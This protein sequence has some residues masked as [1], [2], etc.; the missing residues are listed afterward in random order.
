MFFFNL[1]DHKVCLFTNKEEFLTLLHL[2]AFRQFQNLSEE[3]W[4]H[5]TENLIKLSLR[6]CLHI[7]SVI[8]INYHY[9]TVLCPFNLLNRFKFYNTV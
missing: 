7:R 5:A 9:V 6:K 1:V 8:S 2:R 4:S 3:T